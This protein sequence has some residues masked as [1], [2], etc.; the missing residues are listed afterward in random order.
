[1]E[2]LPQRFSIGRGMIYGFSERSNEADIVVWDALNYPSLPMRGHNFFFAES[3]RSV[4]EVKTSWSSENW[5]DIQNKCHTL[6]RM[7]VFGRPNLLDQLTQIK[8]DIQALREGKK[9][10]TY[11]RLVHLI[12]NNAI[13]FFGGSS[14][15]IDHLTSNDFIFMEE[16]WPEITLLLE[17]GLVIQKRWESVD[18]TPFG[19]KCFLDFIDAGEDALLLFT[20]NFLQGLYE[21]SAHFEDPFYFTPYIKEIIESMPKKSIEI[22]NEGAK[23]GKGH[24]WKDI[25][26]SSIP[27]T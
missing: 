22:P 5:V 21:K 6:S 17:A 26:P 13:I 9:S 8:I 27:D 18:D 24:I 4:I 14:V 16:D 1:M 19:G 23:P 25:D 15:N 3:V 12:A 2:I 7:F 20:V 10:T 11:T